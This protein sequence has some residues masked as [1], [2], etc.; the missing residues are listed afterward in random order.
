MHKIILNTD[1]GI[2][3]ALA[4]FLVLASPEIELI[5]I[6]TNY[7]NVAVNLTTRN[8]LALLELTDSKSIPVARGCASPLVNAPV[9]GSLVHGQNGL[10][11]VELPEPQI[12]PIELY[13]VDLIIEK[14]MANPN[15][16]TLVSI[17]PL[18]N[19][20]LAVRQEPRL[21]QNVREVVLMG[22]ALC[23]PGNI[24]SAAEFNVFADPHAA[25]VVLH[26]GW[27]LRMVTLDVTS[28]VLLSFDRIRT[29]AANGNPV[30]AFIEHAM[31]YYVQYVAGIE[32]HD[33]LCLAALCDPE[34]ITWQHAY[35]D[36]ELSDP[37]TI[38]KTIP[39]FVFPDKE[40]TLPS[41]NALV[42]RDVDVDRF[43]C[44]YV[45][46]LQSRFH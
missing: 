12:Q 11:N 10:C 36:V 6:T 31:E 23:V 18:T 30:T 7:G 25:Q 37:L 15:A 42:S 45:E 8:A 34:L 33:P 39:S 20:A 29:L 46:R 19:L 38:G 24:S 21:V 5:A 16:V 27:P 28:K 14:V 13:A 43:I 26:A 44:M 32:M 1:P 40:N 2:D 22:G 41:F 9:S 17:G 3:D 35:V 4:L